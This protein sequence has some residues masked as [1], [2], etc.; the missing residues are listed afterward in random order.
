MLPHYRRDAFNSG[1]R[2]VGYEI[3]DAHDRID[4][5]DLLVIWNRSGD[6]GLVADAYEAAGA[7][8]IV[9]ENGYI[10]ADSNGHRLFAM[11]KWHH[12][13]AGEWREGAPGRWMTQGIE[14][15]P[16]RSA[17]D[18]I[19]ALPQR[20]IGAAGVAMPKTWPF[21]IRHRIAARTS[22]PFFLRN[23]PGKSGEEPHRDLLGAWAAVTWGSSA[24]IKAIV[25]GIPVFYDFDRWIGAPAALHGLDQIESP[26]MGDR[27]PML[28]RLAWAQWTLTEIESGESFEWLLAS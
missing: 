18:R 1:L 19:V 11:S 7:Q 20:G 23:H 14:L 12:N 15:S 25:A 8:V 17:G 21:E 26:W 24:A 13:G 5:D 16:W 3:V 6:N 22:R 28:N 9:V 10:G 4:P 2:R 27:E